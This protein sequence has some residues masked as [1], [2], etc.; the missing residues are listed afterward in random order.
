MA[1]IVPLDPANKISFN[2]LIC[3]G[4]TVIVYDRHDFMRPHKDH[5]R[6]SLPKPVRT[7]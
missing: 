2:R 5:A 3:D 1:M 7:L 6:I 4:D